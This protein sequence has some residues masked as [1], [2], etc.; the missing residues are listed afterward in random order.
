ML[1]KG[2]QVSEFRKLIQPSIK[3]AE[4]LKTNQTFQQPKS[5]NNLD[6]SSFKIDL[7]DFAKIKKQM[8]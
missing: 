3:P 2:I 8:R 7:S 6:N 5:S 1:S 4:K